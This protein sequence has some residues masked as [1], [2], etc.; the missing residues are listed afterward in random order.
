M[1]AAAFAICIFGGSKQISK[2]TGVL[3]PVM[4][5]FYILVSLIIIVTHLNLSLI[6][7]SGII[8]E[9]KSSIAS[10]KRFS[11]LT[12]FVNRKI[13]DMGREI[14][15]GRITVDPVSYTHLYWLEAFKRQDS[16]A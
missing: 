3:V 15:D 14:L 5:I 2:I 12:G 10:E 6:H 1:L 11:A 16:I 9:A 13:R 8:Q 7:I 4:G